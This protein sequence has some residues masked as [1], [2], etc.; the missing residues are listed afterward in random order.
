MS[1]DR[2]QLIGLDANLYEPIGI[3]RWEKR[4]KPLLRWTKLRIVGAKAVP[5]S[6]KAR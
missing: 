5:R 3:L 4:I 2:L 1:V 6:V